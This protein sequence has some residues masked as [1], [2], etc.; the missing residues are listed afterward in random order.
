MNTTEAL[1]TVAD[2]PVAGARPRRRGAA[3]C[4]WPGAVRAAVGLAML[5]AA[6]AGAGRAADLP[7]L[8]A[9][10][11]ASVVAVEFTTETE[12]DRRVA[13][14][15]GVVV[16]HEGTVILP[17]SAVNERV[18]P[19]QLQDFRIHSPG[20]PTPRYAAATYL[21]QDAFTGWHFLRVAEEG[22]DGLR[23]IGDFAAERERSEPAL[24]EEVWGI[25]LRKKEEDFLPYFMSAR[26]SLL[27]SLPQ[28]TAIALDEVAGPGLP[29]FDQDGVFLG[30]GASGFGESFVM[31]SRVARGGERIALVTPDETAA[32]HLASEVLPHVGRVPGNV[33][34]R[35]RAW[36]GAGGLQPVTA[37]V[38]KF[39]ELDT[40]AGLVVSE[41][42]DGSPARR[43]GL[44]ERDIIL[45]IDGEPLPRLK[46]DAVLPSF[47]ER[48]V[49]RRRPGSN[50]TFGVLRDGRQVEIDVTLGD[51][52]L[53]PREAERRYFDRLGVTAR[54]FVYD[55]AVERRADPEEA[56]GVVA[57]FVKPSSPAASAGLLFDDWIQQIDGFPVAEFEDAA[58][59]LEAIEDDPRRT[60]F[61]LLVRRG[62]GTAL[63]RVRLN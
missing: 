48:E 15:Y 21:G 30:L 50:L 49:N 17:G 41:V 45:S 3:A 31:F 36:L 24:A 28:R 46:P 8:W 19:A 58:A 34:G 29:V 7:A 54:Q 38:A 11:V 43:G 27:Q 9:E 14:A 56:R 6:A 59:R 44:R 40:R 53:R 42:R 22:R 35:P 1:S 16:D 18:T 33:F 51:A 47:L 23:P 61:V 52:P 55:D 37:E 25:G 39:L 4:G 26:V 12:L 60:E 10:R 2:H 13:V 20:E 57:H 5:L 32:F 62:S 63:L